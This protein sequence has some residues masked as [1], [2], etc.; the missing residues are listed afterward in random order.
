MKN[1]NRKK[2]FK[3]KC[4]GSDPLIILSL[5]HTEMHYANVNSQNRSLVDQ[6]LSKSKNFRKCQPDKYNL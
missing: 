3:V 6:W 1:T 5:L 2:N 4:V